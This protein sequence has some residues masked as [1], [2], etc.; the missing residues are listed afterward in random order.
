[1]DT[2]CL[3]IQTMIEFIKFV[4]F[5]YNHSKGKKRAPGNQVLLAVTFFTDYTLQNRT[6]SSEK[7]S[8]S[9]VSRMCIDKS[10][11]MGTMGN[12]FQSTQSITVTYSH[13]KLP[14]SN[15]IQAIH[16]KI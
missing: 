15:K 10:F 16:F 6:E 13:E 9:Q 2:C 7:T 12:T 1:M 5:S 14:H 11:T 4:R 8:Q 3:G